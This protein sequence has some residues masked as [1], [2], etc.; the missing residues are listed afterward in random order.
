MNKLAIVLISTV[1]VVAG[2]NIALANSP[3]SAQEFLTNAMK[4]DNSEIKL[5]QLAADKGQSA[6][7]KTFGQTLVTDHTK[8]KQQVADL[9]RSMGISPTDEMMPKA[10]AEYT[11]LQAMSGAA[12]DK[13][14]ASYMVDDHKSDI[15]DFEA[16]TKATDQTAKLAQ[17]QL[18]KLRK[19]LKMAQSLNGG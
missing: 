2:G 18:P 7:T 11:K 4:G 19:H 8:A 6:G 16:Q 5:G 13:E 1:A 14:F 15:S 10:Q 17:K 12:F 3:K 9:D